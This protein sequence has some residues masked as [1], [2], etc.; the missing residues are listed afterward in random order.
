MKNHCKN[1][2][3]LT[4]QALSLLMAFYILNFSIDSKDIDPDY[5]QEDLSLND[6]ESFYE[7]ILEEVIG[8]ENAVEEHD[9]HDQE[10]GGAFDFEK[11]YLSLPHSGMQPKQDIIRTLHFNISSE[12]LIIPGFSKIDSP[13][14]KG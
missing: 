9:E 10:E 5:I 11:V 4:R 3:I 7:L 8:I 13:P 14:P 12:N 6:I 2:S 1:W